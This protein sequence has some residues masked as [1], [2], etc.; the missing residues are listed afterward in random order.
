MYFHC[1]G[2]S[3]Y[4]HERVARVATLSDVQTTA[5]PD[6]VVTVTSWTYYDGDRVQEI[7]NPG[8]NFSGPLIK[9]FNGLFQFANRISDQTDLRF[10]VR[11]NMVRQHGGV[12]ERKDREREGGEGRRGGKESKERSERDCGRDASAAEPTLLM[13]PSPYMPARVDMIDPAPC[14]TLACGPYLHQLQ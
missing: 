12:G 14:A 6:G 11:P 5:A 7:A 10:Y 8:D 9:P 1:E 4:P 2:A 3:S 13:A